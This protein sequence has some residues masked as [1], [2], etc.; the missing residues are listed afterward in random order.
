MGPKES[1]VFAVVLVGFLLGNILP[2]GAGPVQITPTR[3]YQSSVRS[4]VQSPI[5]PTGSSVAPTAGD[6]A[7]YVPHLIPVGQGPSGIAYDSIHGRI[8]V[9]NPG[10]RN[11]SVINDST[12]QVVATVALP[13]GPAGVAYDNM[14]NR[15]FVSC[16]YQLVVIDA[17]TY[18]IVTTLPI[19]G[20]SP[21]NVAVDSV[22]GKVYIAGVA[23]SNVTIVNA[24]NMTVSGYLKVTLSPPNSVAVDGTRHLVYVPNSAFGEP[25]GGGGVSVYSELDNS[26]VGSAPSGLNPNAMVVDFDSGLLYVGD[27]GSNEVSV[28]SQGNNSLAATIP[29]PGEPSGLSYDRADR[30]ILVGVVNA[31]QA[32]II[33]GSTDAVIGAVPTGDRPEGLTYD[34]ATR[35]LYVANSGSNTV[36]AIPLTSSTADYPSEVSITPTVASLP[37]GASKTFQATATCAPWACVGPLSFQW[38]LSDSLA[39]LNASDRPSITVIAGSQPGSDSLI[40]TASLNGVTTQ[41]QPTQIGILPGLSAVAVAP[42][43]VSVPLQSAQAFTVFT[44][45][46]GGPCPQG[47]TFNWSLGSSPGTLNATT[48][49]TVVFLAGNQSGTASLTVQATLDGRTLE[50]SATIAVGS[51]TQSPLAGWF[52]LPGYDGFYVTLGILATGLAVVAVWRLRNRS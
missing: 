36:S 10:S 35:T 41:S 34:G 1:S 14:D 11:L 8:Y 25:T 44:S 31:N 3:E 24:A 19:G 4:G 21:F 5:L 50:A 9:A 30:F 6:L 2:D 26:F 52:G 27:A 23:F 22:A 32:L 39:T 33:N 43:S 49:S 17:T 20:G 7:A 38:A 18:S 45:C 16:Q 51:V 12:E 47:A 46:T 28:I 40:V 13:S 42:T 48:G 37:T 29:L 15:L